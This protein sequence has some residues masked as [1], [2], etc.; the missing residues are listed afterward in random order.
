[1]KENKI[2]VKGFPALVTIVIIYSIQCLLVCSVMKLLTMFLPID[3]NLELTVTT[4]VT[5]KVFQIIGYLI[6]FRWK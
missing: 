1:M 6:G 5:C 2:N 3:F 4:F